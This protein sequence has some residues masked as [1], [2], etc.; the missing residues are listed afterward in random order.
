M[1]MS[2]S[3]LALR[4]MHEPKYVLGLRE[5]E[6]GAQQK[7]TENGDEKKRQEQRAANSGR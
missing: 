5:G 7:A 1:L 2:V 4:A 3:R 6:T